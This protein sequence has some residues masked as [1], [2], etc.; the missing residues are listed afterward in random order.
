MTSS[1][2]QSRKWQLIFAP[3]AI[4]LFFLFSVVQVFFY[5]VFVY[6]W[7]VCF[8]LMD[9]SALIQNKWNGMEPMVLQRIM[10]PSIARANGQLESRRS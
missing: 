10:W 1:A 2:L 7:F 8:L 9:P 4:F 3:H 5:F 6:M